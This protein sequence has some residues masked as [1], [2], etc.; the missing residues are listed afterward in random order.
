VPD[1]PW[2]GTSI[3]RPEYEAMAHAT[4]AHALDF[5]DSLLVSNT[6]PSSVAIP[7][8]LSIASRR[9]SLRPRVIS[10]HAIGLGINVALGKALNYDDYRKGWHSTATI[11]IISTTAALA[12]LM[13][14]DGRKSRTALALA[15]AQAGGL[16]RNFGTSAKALQ[17]GF[18]SA[19]AVRAALLAEAGVTAD[20]DIFDR[21]GYFD[22]YGGEGA[23]DRAETIEIALGPAVLARKLFPCC[24]GSHRMITAAF[25]VRSDLSPADLA[26]ARFR[27]D[28]PYAAMHAMKILDPKDEEQAKFCAKYIIAIA[29]IEGKVDF[30]HFLPECIARSDV[31][32]LMQRIEI[33]EAAPTDSLAGLQAGVVRL[34]VTVDDQ[35]VAVAICEDHPGSSAAPLTALQMNTKIQD[36]LAHYAVTTGRKI[37]VQEFHDRI[38]HLTH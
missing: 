6:H 16:K 19:G 27:L 21:G 18:A 37:S 8:L 12:H 3:V 2:F 30:S 1:T 7:A 22:L 25:D 4:A 11:T 9:P 5:D 34:S 35:T 36:C 31:K 24:Y 29:L 32:A 33:S 17:V 28:V 20:Q 38:D 14:F 15:A 13:Q 10:S 26:T 23:R